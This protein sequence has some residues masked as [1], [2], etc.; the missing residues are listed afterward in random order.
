[1]MWDALYRKKNWGSQRIGNYLG[2]SFMTVLLRLKKLGYEI[3]PSG[4]ANN[5]GPQSSSCFIRI[6]ELNHPNMTQSAI[7]AKLRLSIITVR[8]CVHNYRLD[9]IRSYNGEALGP[10]R[11]PKHL[12]GKHRK[13]NPCLNHRKK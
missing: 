7:A 9:Y 10:V 11:Y 5:I 8:H 13:E 1:H 3:K 2:V 12:T 4:G 6:Q